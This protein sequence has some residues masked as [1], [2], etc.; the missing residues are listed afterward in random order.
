MKNVEVCINSSQV[1]EVFKKNL[2]GWK[3]PE[4]QKAILDSWGN[5]ERVFDNAIRNVEEFVNHIQELEG[6]DF[7]SLQRA[8]EEL[9]FL[10]VMHPSDFE[11]EDIFYD[12]D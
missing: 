8:R 5:M 6:D 2:L 9:A 4:Q 1:T 7:D 10:F 11:G 12:N 3:S